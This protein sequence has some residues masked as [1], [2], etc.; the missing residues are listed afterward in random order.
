MTAVIN[1]TTT[2]AVVIC[3]APPHRCALHRRRRWSFA[4]LLL[5]AAL[6]I[7]A[8]GGHA[9]AVALPAPDTVG[10]LIALVS[11]TGKRSSDVVI[12]LTD[13]AWER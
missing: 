12:S 6:C 3:A 8:G 5:I 11:S 10:R 13:F 1:V 7:V 2:R 4:P 9:P